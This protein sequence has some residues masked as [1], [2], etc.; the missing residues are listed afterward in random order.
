MSKRMAAVV[1]IVLALAGAGRA[2]GLELKTDE[3]KVLY[4]LGLVIGENLAAFNLTAAELELVSAGLADSVLKKKPAVDLQAFGPRLQEFQRARLAAAVETEKKAGQAFAA[5]AAVE[6]G[7]RRTASGAI[8]T[9][10]T[11][12][13]GAVPKPT[14]QVRVHYHGTLVDGTVFDSSVQRG[15]PASV[16]LEGVIPCWREGL[17]QMKVGGKYRL[18]CPAETA[19]GDRGAP[20]RIKPGAT[21]VFEVELLD[22]AK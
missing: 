9:A 7:A 16:P 8:V 3:Q 18:V 4:A 1:T 10:I 17:Q 14:D 15:A 12:G 13:T 21:L 6:K 11:P 20:P 19:Y 5:R 2:A 22:I